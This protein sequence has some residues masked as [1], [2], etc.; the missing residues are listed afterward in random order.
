MNAQSFVKHLT[1]VAV[2]SFFAVANVGAVQILCNDDDSIN[3][4][5]ID[6]ATVA[7]CLGSGTEPALTGD[8]A[9]DPF[10]LSANGAGYQFAGKLNA[11]GLEEN[12]L[13]DISFTQAAEEGPTGTFSFDSSFWDV[14]ASGAVGFKFGTGQGI[15]RW[16]VYSLQPGT[17]GGDW[18][19]LNRF[20][21]GGGLSHVALYANTPVSVPEPGTLALLGLG[22]LGLGL[23]RRR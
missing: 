8:P 1:A 10:L 14:W 2:L 13:F 3:Q 12:N 19:F 5:S 21:Q 18:S 6:S 17:T 11:D 20:D 16:F 23:K 7:A 22:L 15:D 9:S 4:M